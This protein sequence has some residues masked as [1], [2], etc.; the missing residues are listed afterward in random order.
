M[1][2]K[3]ISSFYDVVVIGSGISGLTSA[4]LLSKSGLS[5]CVLEQDTQVGGYL[6]NFS[7]KG[8]HFSTS[9]HWLNQCGED[10][11]VTKIFNFISP[12]VPQTL[13]QKRIRRIKGD[14]FDYLLT[15]NPEEL[16][17]ELIEK[18][19][20]DE[21]GIVRFF[22]VAKTIGK[23]FKKS[24]S[25]FRTIETM[26]LWEKSLFGLRALKSSLPFFKWLPYST[27]KGL[28]KFFTEEGLKKIF[29]TEEDFISCLAPIGWAYMNDFQNPPKGGS[30]VFPKWLCG[31]L[32]K[33]NV[34]LF[35][36]C[37]VEKV[38][39]EKNVAV[40][41]EAMWKGETRTIKAGRVVSTGDIE[42]LYR[43]ML[44]PGKEQK[45][46]L[47]RFKN[48][49]IY[50]SSVTLYL[51]L[52]CLPSE[53]G[54]QEEAIFYSRDDVSRKEQNGG[55]PHK[56]TLNVISPSL[57]D[58]SMAPAGKGTVMI[59]VAAELEYG[60]QWKTETGPNGE[61]IRGK[62][63]RAFKKEYAD[64]ILQRVEEKIAPG[65]RDH[66]EVCEIATP[67]TF[68]RYTKNKGGTMMGTR[69][70][71]KNMKAKVAGYQTFIKNLY[72]AGHWAEY[73]GGVPPAV[74]AATNASLLITKK[75]NP[76]FFKALAGLTDGRIDV[77]EAQK[78]S[79]K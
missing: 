79:L 31:I 59:F 22:D 16:K 9:I 34:D 14:S 73:G 4:A 42:T 64:I 54:L 2:E 76:Q 12:D 78:S 18:F 75:T 26:S 8:F 3:E 17:Q 41:V 70:G 20:K 68:L 74:R 67:V 44:P 66:I 28:K 39:V 72:I 55:D 1:S 63:Y 5:V 6:A 10:G 60:D 35:L 65:L 7:R 38:L 45:D 11:I 43:D 21:K 46:Y 24:S 62:A 37:S 19:P 27:E 40:G 33:Q 61:I 47:E 52:D 56:S 71:M 57:V 30:E 49:E 69:P 15:Q 23:A 58:P 53:L 13:E 77:V 36:R 48:A 25:L 51:G 50:S 29:C 32:E